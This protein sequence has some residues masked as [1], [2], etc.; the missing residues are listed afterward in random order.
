MGIAFLLTMGTSGVLAHSPNSTETQGPRY[1]KTEVVSSSL[2]GA[3]TDNPKS[4]TI[5]SGAQPNEHRTIEQLEE[6]CRKFHQWLLLTSDSRNIEKD[7]DTGERLIRGR[8]IALAELIERNPQLA[9]NHAL[10]IDEIKRLPDAWLG[11][12]EKHFSGIGE[13]KVMSNCSNPDDDSYIQFNLNDGTS[14]RGK[15][16][17]KLSEIRSK[18]A[19]RL[20]GF[21]IAGVAAFYELSS[22]NVGVDSQNMENSKQTNNTKYLDDGGSDTTTAA[23]A[24]TATVESIL[25]E[26]GKMAGPNA[27]SSLTDAFADDIIR[28]PENVLKEAAELSIQWTSQPKSVLVLN[29]VFQ[30]ETAAVAEP[31]EIESAFKT[32]SIWLSRK[33]YGKIELQVKVPTNLIHLPLS[34]SSYKSIDLIHSHAASV[35]QGQGIDTTKPDIVVV[36]FPKIE[37]IPWA[38]FATIGGGETW[39]NGNITV[40]VIAH[41]IGHNLGLEH[42]SAWNDSSDRIIPED[43][44]PPTSGMS[45]IEYGDLFSVMGKSDSFP[46][47]DFSPQAKRD[48]GWISDGQIASAT[49]SGVYRLYSFDSESSASNSPLAIRIP[50]QGRQNLWLGY[51]REFRL[52]QF[53]YNG[54]YS[55]WQYED[56]KCRLLDMT[57]NSHAGYWEYDFYDSPLQIGESFFYQTNRIVISPLQSGVSA[58]GEWIDVEVQFSVSQNSP[59]NA[60]IQI[61]STIL[62]VGV[63]VRFSASGGDSDG[64]SIHYIW[65]FGGGRLQFGSETTHTFIAGGEKNVKLY[66]IDGKGGRSSS[67]K[68]FNVEDSIQFWTGRS[69]ELSRSETRTKY[70]AGAAGSASMLIIGGVNCLFFKVMDLDQ[71]K[72]LRPEALPFLSSGVAWSPK[73]YEIVGLYGN[74]PNYKG[75]TM[76]VGNDGQFDDPIFHDFPALNGISATID[77]YVAVGDNGLIAKSGDGRTWTRREESIGVSLTTV[78]FAG[79]LGLAGGPECLM[80]SDDNGNTWVRIPVPSSGR[81][82]WPRLFSTGDKIFAATGSSLL[83]FKPESNSWTTDQLDWSDSERIT[84]IIKTGNRYCGLS[85]T[86]G[87]DGNSV[88]KRLIVSE[89]G[90]NW[91][92]VSMANEWQPYVLLQSDNVLVGAGEDALFLNEVGVPSLIVSPRQFTARIGILDTGA[93]GIVRIENSGWKSMDWSAVADNNWVLL[94]KDHGRVGLKEDSF[95]I[96]L[97]KFDLPGDYRSSIRISSGDMVPIVVDVNVRVFQDDFGGAKFNAGSLKIGQRVVGRIDD[98]DDEDWFVFRIDAV[99]RVVI[100]SQGRVDTWGE[101]YDSTTLLQA[102]NLTS[103][104]NSNFWIESDLIPG[105][106]W[107]RVGREA[108]RATDYAVVSRFVQ[109]GPT[110]SFQNISLSAD[111]RITF[112]VGTPKGYLYR[113]EWIES[114]GDTEWNAASDS[115]LASSDVTQFSFTPTS[116]SGRQI[117]FRVVMLD[118]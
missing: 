76:H 72:R 91:E 14:L 57:P 87:E 16:W 110:F 71:R 45:H 35:A 43:P 34:K 12:V 69:L 38:G 107:L 31:P 7:P 100:Y 21:Q 39:L 117:L 63:P 22:R 108:G 75:S 96:S 105:W 78:A 60:N 97:G 55:L 36:I 109:S 48:L 25:F 89:D 86:Q 23:K 84:S 6:E 61:D 94:S 19:F 32:V 112:T 95:R 64:D 81:Q 73:G 10:S 54:V 90:Q 59:P 74:W 98:Q 26:I 113:L 46:E 93:E 42:S 82:F 80:R 106:Y 56:H 67:E 30:G 68:R 47:G 41:E 99:G 83:L 11:F 65:D 118:P 9:I 15:R 92:R 77:G 13:L 51:R 50:L 44:I 114:L 27:G 17:G 102:S 53:L 33:S 85:E 20:S 8:F 115:V 24:H 103:L 101:L 58:T 4:Q 111:G 2:R 40:G 52:N 1:S 18:K 3:R 62:K 79:S 104:M 37:E 28:N 88:L 66:A 49:K 5:I 29:A 116:D 70:S